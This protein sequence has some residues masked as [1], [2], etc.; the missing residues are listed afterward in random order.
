MPLIEVGYPIVFKETFARSGLN[1]KNLKI[2]HPRES[3]DPY[4]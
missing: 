3:G 1:A 2:R 4:K